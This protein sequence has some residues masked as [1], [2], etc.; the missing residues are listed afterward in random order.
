MKCWVLHGNSCKTLTSCPTCYSLHL[1]VCYI[2]VPPWPC[3]GFVGCVECCA[4]C[5]VN[6]RTT[7][8]TRK[9]VFRLVLDMCCLMCCANI[10]TTN[11]P[12]MC[13]ANKRTT[14]RKQGSKLPT[15][16]RGCSLCYKCV[17]P[18]YASHF[19]RTK[20]QAAAAKKGCSMAQISPVWHKF[21]K[22]SA[23][24][25]LLCKGTV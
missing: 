10:R 15:Q 24:V 18:T 12:R 14:L 6:T 13:S 25:Y 3:K 21:W 2:C 7:L 8:R 5:C 4:M 20:Q 17:P 11:V 19:T 1:V 23:L 16:K 9:N 22:V